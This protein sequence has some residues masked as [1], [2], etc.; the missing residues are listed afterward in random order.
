M[1]RSPTSDSD[2]TSI[3]ITDEQRLIDAINYNIE[4][5]IHKYFLSLILFLFL[6]SLSDKLIDKFL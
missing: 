5:K 2:L 3:N 6:Q 1:I 4:K